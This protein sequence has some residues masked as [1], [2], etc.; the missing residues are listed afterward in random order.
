MV[1]NKH[2][3]TKKNF[4]FIIILTSINYLKNYMNPSLIKAL[5]PIIIKVMKPIIRLSL[6][7]IV[8]ISFSKITHAN[9]K[10]MIG[11]NKLKKKRF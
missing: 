11:K 2:F 5:K 7:A 1:F 10:I 4:L 8:E 9:Q 3:L 6:F